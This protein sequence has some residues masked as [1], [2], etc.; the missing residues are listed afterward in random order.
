MPSERWGGNR[1][2]SG[3]RV[4]RQIPL[5]VI[6]LCMLFGSGQALAQERAANG[7]GGTVV[8]RLSL[9]GVVVVETRA[10]TA[11]ADLAARLADAHEAGQFQKVFEAK[12]RPTSRDRHHRIG[13]NPVG[14]ADWNRDQRPLRVVVVEH[15][16][17]PVAP[18]RHQQQRLA[19]ER[20]EGMNNAKHSSGIVP[21][22]WKI[23]VHYPHP[24]YE[25]GFEGDAFISTVDFVN[26]VRPYYV[27]YR[28]LY[29]RNIPNLFMA[30]R[31]ISVTREA[32]GTVRVM[33]TTALMGE[34]V[35]MAATL[36][37][38]HGIDPRAV[39]EKHLAGPRQTT[40]RERTGNAF[41]YE[42]HQ[43]RHLPP[44]RKSGPFSAIPADCR[45]EGGR[46]L[47]PGAGMR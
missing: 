16:L 15:V 21:T 37:A 36:C 35:G 20:M 31:D 14:P 47:P 7:S 43:D 11:G 44:V 17:A 25:K 28:C 13:G 34:V 46:P 33:K 5:W 4:A 38:Q 42:L 30:G 45:M 19:T 27:P 6:L 32:L 1:L 12:R 2:G 3:P 24:T 40:L 41:L 9:D 39:Y 10:D 29:S 8:R 23:D 26:C 22:G 18:Y